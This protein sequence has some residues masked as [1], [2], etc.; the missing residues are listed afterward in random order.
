MPSRAP[1]PR[2]LRIFSGLRLDL[3]VQVESRRLHLTDI[4]TTASIAGP[5]DGPAVVLLHGFPDDRHGWDRQIEP[6]AEAGFRAIA[7]DQ[8]GCGEAGFGDSLRAYTASRLVDDVEAALGD[9]GIS[10]AHLVGHD[11]GGLVAWTAALEERP[12]LD[13]LVIMNVPHPAVFA[14]FVRSHP[15]QLLRSWYM[16]FFQLPWL[17]ER[18]L[19]ARGAALVSKALTLSATARAFTDE[20]LDRYRSVWTEPGRITGML[21]WYRAMRV[22]P[23]P[24]GRVATP[25]LIIWGERDVALDHRLADLS[26]ERCDD[27][28]V[29]RLNRA[30]HWPHR[31]MPAEVNELCIDHLWT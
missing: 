3:V 20:E 26:A 12:W 11:W 9:L 6:L 30:S 15:R 28:T 18:L 29:A 22:G 31:D 5:P 27:V 25:T 8:R 23:V 16:L 1:S 17:P 19:A 21:D 24:N 14:R 13:R 7:L 2:R 4:Q 10:R